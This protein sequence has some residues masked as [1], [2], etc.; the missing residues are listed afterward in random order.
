[1]H[2]KYR[3]QLLASIHMNRLPNGIQFFLDIAAFSGFI[4]LIGRLGDTELAAS[5][6]AFNISMLAFMP[7][8]GLGITVSILVGQ[9]LGANHP[10][11][12]KTATFSALQMSFTYMTVLALLYLLL[13]TVFIYPF[14]AK[15][16][17]NEF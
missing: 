9:S 12:A 8:I 4:L 1:M 10:A 16:D 15:A 14:C 11:R 3:K 17:T 5:N 13:P 6:I 7:M 2:N